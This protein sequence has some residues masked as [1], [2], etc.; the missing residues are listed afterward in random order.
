MG[1]KVVLIQEMYN[2]L[3]AAIQ[4]GGALQGVKRVMVGS[5][6]ET[7]REIKYP[8]IRIQQQG[9]QEIADHPNG[10]FSDDMRIRI[11][12]MDNKLRSEA[13][14]LFD[15]ATSSGALY[16]LEAVMNVLDKTTDGVLDNTFSST[17]GYLKNY[18][19]SIE[20]D[21]DSVAIALD[22]DVRTKPF[23]RGAR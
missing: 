3:N 19:Y 10:M 14:Q 18:S 22:I 8:H 11:V 20:T 1:V 6:D 9:G 21:N 12:I 4:S 5:L 17:A 16:L 7:K 23:M 2:R 13:N 15:T